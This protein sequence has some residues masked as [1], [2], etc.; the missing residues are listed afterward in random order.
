[1]NGTDHYI[2]N[3][4]QRVFESNPFQPSVKT[5]MNGFMMTINSKKLQY[6]SPYFKKNSL[7]NDLLRQYPPNEHL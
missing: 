1:M 2:E 7:F 5:Q 3:D 6:E 4:I